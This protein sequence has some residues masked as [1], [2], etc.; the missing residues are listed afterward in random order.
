MTQRELYP[1]LIDKGFEHDLALHFAAKLSTIQKE[2]VPCLSG[3]LSRGEEQDFSVED[4]SISFFMEVFQL[5]YPAA[6]VTVDWLLREP[7]V[8]KKAIQQGI[9]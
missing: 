8:A 7:E 5:S 2:L 1:L 4:F 9:L 6:L 3:W